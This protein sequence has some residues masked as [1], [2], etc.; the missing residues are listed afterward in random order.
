M[1]T[2]GRRLYEEHVARAP[3]LGGCGL[4]TQ[5]RYRTVFDKFFVFAKGQKIESWGAVDTRVLEQYINS[6]TRIGYIT[7]TGRRK[8]YC[9]KT[10][11]N[12]LVTLMQCIHWLS[13]N[14]HLPE[15]EF[16]LQLPRAESERPYCW[17]KNEVAAMVKYCR[18]PGL[19]WLG[20][21][22]A[23]LACT[24]L[25]ISELAS[26]RWSDIDFVKE[27]FTLTDETAHRQT[28]LVS[29]RQTKSHRSRSLPIHEDLL[30]VLKQCPKSGIFVFRGPRGGRLKADTVRNV[31]ITKVLY[32]L[33]EQFPSSNGVKGFKEGRLHSFRHYFCSDCANSNVP[34]L[35]VMEWLGHADSDMVRHYYHL[36]DE[37]SQRQMKRLTLL[38]DAG[39]RFAGNDNRT[40]VSNDGGFAQPEGVRES[41]EL[42]C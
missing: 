7:P 4:S 18:R 2:E 9:Y 41:R 19:V 35:T 42:A 17:K 15:K 10:L 34:E 1:L 6:L 13:K 16:D 5:K 31:L 3:V 25:R 11:R 24:G 8:E 12:E 30:D 33:A 40:A 28:V 32:P 20:N 22:L 26:L 38:G 29:R 27:K 14:G 21:V 37:E 36:N 23:A 39:K